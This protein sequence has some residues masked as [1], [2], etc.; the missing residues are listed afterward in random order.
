MGGRGPQTFKK[1][2]KEQQ[3][4]DRQLAK[5]EKKLQRKQNKGPEGAET[6]S[7][8][9]EPLEGDAFDSD[10]EPIEQDSDAAG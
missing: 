2:Q 7:G 8:G 5:A 9:I 3:R 6:E 1:R 4:K 10:G